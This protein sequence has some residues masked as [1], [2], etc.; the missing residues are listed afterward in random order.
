CVMRQVLPIAGAIVGA[1][2]GNPQLGFMIGSLIGNAVDPM[3]IEGSK[4]GDNPLQTAAEGGA[5]AIV[6][7]TGCVRATCLLERGNRQVVEVEDQA[8]KGGP[9]TV[10]ERVYW[11]FAIGLGE[12]IPGGAIIRIWEGEK[13]VYDASPDSP[14]PAET[15]EFARKFRF[16]DGSED[17]LP[18][19]AL[20]AISGVG[21][22]HYYRG[23]A[24]VVFPN[25]DLT[26]YREQIPVYRWEIASVAEVEPIIGANVVASR[27]FDTN[28]I[29]AQAYIDGAGLY[30]LE[31]QPL[32]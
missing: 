18:D 29:C 6:F 11:T 9:V 23:T 10:N 20:E 32:T 14:I 24:Y 19:P 27:T 22:A 16:Y 12:A 2:F 4:V 30:M 8:G 13:L 25:Y 15:T 31:G 5:R 7:G 17:Q 26:D 1:Y 28:P 21:N 3:E